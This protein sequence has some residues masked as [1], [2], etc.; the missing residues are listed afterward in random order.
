MA[1]QSLLRYIFRRGPRGRSQRATSTPEA[2]QT[3]RS[4]SPIMRDESHRYLNTTAM[5]NTPEPPTTYQSEPMGVDLAPLS[6]IIEEDD[7]QPETA[8]LAETLAALELNLD[9]FTT[10]ELINAATE[11]AKLAISAH[12]ETIDATLALL[13]ALDGFS[14]T[15]TVMMQEMK[16]KKAVCKEKLVMIA[17]VERAVEKMQFGQEDTETEED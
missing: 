2:P 8:S 12:L 5:G 14:D 15:I 6:Q 16:D 4:S 1:G 10:R 3:A 17:D 7:E 11:E 13:N 9:T